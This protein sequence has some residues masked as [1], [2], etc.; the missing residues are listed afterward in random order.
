VYSSKSADVDTV[1]CNGELLMQ[2][3]KLLTIDKG[4]VKKEISAR[5]ERLGQRTPGKRIAVYPA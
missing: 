2:G 3:R 5:L 4:Q 1:I